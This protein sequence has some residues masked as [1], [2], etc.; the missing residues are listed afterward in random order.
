[1]VSGRTLRGPRGGIWEPKPLAHANRPHTNVMNVKQLQLCKTARLLVDRG[2]SKKYL[3]GHWYYEV[4]R[5]ESQA[6]PSNFPLVLAPRYPCEPAGKMPWAS[7]FD[8]RCN[9]ASMRRLPT[10]SPSIGLEV[11]NMVSLGPDFRAL[12]RGSNVGYLR[13]FVWFSQH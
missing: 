8:V 7:M 12:P 4:C 11:R 1:M 13:A 3:R 5:L 6:S 10:F 9:D 2:N